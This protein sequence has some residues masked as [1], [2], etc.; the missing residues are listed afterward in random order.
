MTMKVFVALLLLVSFP[1]TSWG[2]TLDEEKKYGREIYLEIVKSSRLI[3]DPYACLY[4]G[5]MGRRLDQAAEIPFPLR[6]TLIHS[7]TANAFAT[8]GGYVYVTS[9]LIEMADTEEELAGV[10][11]HEL[12]HVG[13]RHI[14]KRIE[15]EKYLN[16]GM[17]A[18][19]LLSALVPGGAAVQQALMA[20]SLGAAQ[21]L[22]L[23][24]SREDETDADRVG[25]AT[26]EKAGYNGHGIA[27]FLKKIRAAEPG[28]DVPQYLL[29]HPYPEDRAIKIESMVTLEK[30]KMETDLFPQVV[31]RFRILD[32]QFNPGLEDTWV[33]RYEKDPKNP[34]SAYGASLVYSLK[35]DVD[36]AA[37]IAGEIDSPYRNLLLGEILVRG[38][39]F[40][41]AAEVLRAGTD[42]ISR[43]YYAVAL[44]GKGDLQEAATVLKGLLPWYTSFPA[45]FQKYAMVVGRLGNEGVGFEYLGRYYLETGRDQAA[46]LYFQKALAAYGR[47]SEEGRKLRDEL[48]EMKDEKSKEEPK[49]T[50]QKKLSGS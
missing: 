25:L 17:I 12:A 21:G 30:N 46:R 5:Q 22:S 10:L 36:R 38:Q 50:Q 40:A 39:R 20:S 33:K 48:G 32:K 27:Q 43:Y 23:K 16:M 29:T 15:K 28:K 44:E 8:M 31:A 14:S 34:T 13:R 41:E 47:N 7:I 6:M 35:G 24:Y 9:A 4:L 2:L 42:P 37:A 18:A 19:L 45:I 49:N 3:N 1:A 26:A 11:A